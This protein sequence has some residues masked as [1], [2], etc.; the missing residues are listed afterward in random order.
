MTTANRLLALDGATITIDSGFLVLGGQGPL[1]APCPV[2][3]IEHAR[4]LVLFDTG[5]APQAWD[6]ARSVYGDLLDVC[7]LE[8]PPANRLD[9]Q[10][11]NHG[12]TPED[13]THVVISHGHWDHTGGLHLFPHAELFMSIEDIRYAFWQD[14]PYAAFFRNG[15]DLDRARSFRW[16]PLSWD[17]DL[18]GDGSIQILRTPGHTEGQLSILVKLPSRSYFLTGDAVHVRSQVEQI[19]PCPVDANAAASI[20][21][22]YRINQLAAAHQADIWVMHDPDDW[23]RFGADNVHS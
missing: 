7:R 11:A 12:F 18:F 14:P 4:G 17:L 9:R 2:F 19:S 5:V 23:A 15:V 21:S 10:L 22:I 16:N 1:A 8:L 6:D 20:Q 13:V 3:L